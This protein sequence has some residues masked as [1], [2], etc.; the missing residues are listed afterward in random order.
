MRKPFDL[1]TESGAGEPRVI[2]GTIVD[3]QSERIVIAGN[4]VNLSERIRSLGARLYFPEQ[5]A[6]P[7]QRTIT[8]NLRFQ[9]IDPLGSSLY[10]GGY[11]AVFAFEAVYVVSQ[12]G[13]AV[14]AR[15]VGNLIACVLVFLSVL[16]FLA[17]EAF[18]AGTVAFSPWW[19]ARANLVSWAVFLTMVFGL[20][21]FTWF[22]PIPPSVLGPA[23]RF[24][25]TLLIISCILTT[26][27]QV[28]FGAGL[29]KRTTLI[30][31]AAMAF[32]ILAVPLLPWGS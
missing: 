8:G 18:E 9:S 20:A 17:F 6:A 11:G 26:L 3:V 23:V 2:V 5:E 32:L 22:V 12:L 21:P 29:T 16:G 14:A 27:G 15:Q 7:I 4:A 13:E 28:F 19:T 24:L 10:I 30:W 1:R 25:G 31:W